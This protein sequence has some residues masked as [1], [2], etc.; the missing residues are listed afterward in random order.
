MAIPDLPATETTASAA[1]G[2]PVPGGHGPY[3]RARTLSLPDAPGA[4][5]GRHHLI[6]VPGKTPGHSPPAPIPTLGGSSPS[7]PYLSPSPG[8]PGGIIPYPSDSRPALRPAPLSLLFLS[9]L[10]PRTA[11]SR[12]ACPSRSPPRSTRSRTFSE[13]SG[14]GGHS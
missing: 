4:S 5:G 6:L 13:H 1:G 2:N 12:P 9:A 8:L 14:H 3:L 11:T 7:L 10:L